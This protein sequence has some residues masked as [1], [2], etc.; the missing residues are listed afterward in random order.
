MR[1]GIYQVGHLNRLYL[2]RYF[3]LTNDDLGEKILGNSDN[4]FL[5]M[6]FSIKI[7]DFFEM[8]IEF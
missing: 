1:S 7:C 4:V 6:I 2:C 5:L 3:F 8:T